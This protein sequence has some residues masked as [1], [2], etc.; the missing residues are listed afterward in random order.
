MDLPYD[1]EAV[2]QYADLMRFLNARKPGGD[3]RLTEYLTQVRGEEVVDQYRFYRIYFNN[4]ERSA[5]DADLPA[6]AKK[7]KI[8]D[9]QNEFA[10]FLVYISF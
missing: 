10:S 1:T 8:Q 7:L 5:L 2:V 4:Q 9:P 6:I 3:E